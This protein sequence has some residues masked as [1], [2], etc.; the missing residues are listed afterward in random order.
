[1]SLTNIYARVT[2]TPVDIWFCKY[3]PETKTCSLFKLNYCRNRMCVA[4][5]KNS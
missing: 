2:D 1:M 3:F 4:V 5:L